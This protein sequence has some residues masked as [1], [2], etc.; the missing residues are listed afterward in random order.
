LDLKYGKRE[1]FHLESKV[2]ERVSLFRMADCKPSRAPIETSLKLSTED[3]PRNVDETLYR[4]LVGSSIYLSFSMPELCFV[5]SCVSRVM[6][7]ASV[8]HW[9]DV[10]RILRYIKG[11]LDLGVEFFYNGRFNLTGITDLN[12]VGS[13]DERKSTSVYV[14]NLG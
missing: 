8:A 11:M 4:Q 1:H 10:K 7:L 14:F 12:W 13:P 5:V 3:D 6:S 9:K 2:V